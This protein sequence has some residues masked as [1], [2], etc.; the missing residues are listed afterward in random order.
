M[1]KPIKSCW[2]GAIAE[3]DTDQCATHNAEDRKAARQEK[4]FKTATKV[5]VVTEKRAGEL[6]EFAKLKKEYL[7]A[8][9]CCEVEGCN[10][11]SVDVHHQ[12][13]REGE[14]L[15]DINFFMAVCRWHHIEITEHS[16]EAIKKGYSKSRTI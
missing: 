3:G 12:K 15:L 5:K 6:R 11:R 14:L 1:I 7:E 13:G 16:K 4:K 10:E 2:C 9:M 8:Y